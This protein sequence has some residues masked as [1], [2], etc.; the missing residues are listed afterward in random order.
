VSTLD[1]ETLV[2]DLVTAETTDKARNIAQQVEAY[3]QR[4]NYNPSLQGVK[5][6]VERRGFRWIKEQ[7]VVAILA[8]CK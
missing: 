5:A 1:D 3:R 6:I 7:E 8:G 4:L 2:A